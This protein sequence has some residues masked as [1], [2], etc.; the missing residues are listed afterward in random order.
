MCRGGKS[1]SSGAGGTCHP[2]DNLSHTPEDPPLKTLG[3]RIYAQQCD[4]CVGH[5]GKSPAGSG[6]ATPLHQ[7]RLHHSEGMASSSQED[8]T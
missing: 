5:H 2:Q 4:R 1:L 3:Y 8:S 6:D 7:P